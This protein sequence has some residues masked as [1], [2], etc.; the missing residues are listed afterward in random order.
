MHRVRAI[1]YPGDLC[2][3][4][5]ESWLAEPSSMGLCST[6]QVFRFSATY[7]HPPISDYDHLL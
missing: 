3:F 5:H 2:P 4:V 6:A 1:A 7:T